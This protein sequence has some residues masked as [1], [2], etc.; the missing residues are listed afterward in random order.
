MILNMILGFLC[1][2]IQMIT[3]ITDGNIT[4]GNITDIKNSGEIVVEQYTPRGTGRRGDR[5]DE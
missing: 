2:S 5:D 1:L 3:N 4:D